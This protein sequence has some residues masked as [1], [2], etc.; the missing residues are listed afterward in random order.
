MLENIQAF[1]TNL[2]G[3]RKHKG[4]VVSIKEKKMTTRTTYNYSTGAEEEETFPL[5][6][7][8]SWLEYGTKHQPERP[9]V[10]RG[11]EMFV[12]QGWVKRVVEDMITRGIGMTE[13]KRQSYG[14]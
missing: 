9:I 2:A 10:A 3:E 4:Y 11:F 8:L 1:R 5:W 14:G 12:A 6:Y 13:L 7:K